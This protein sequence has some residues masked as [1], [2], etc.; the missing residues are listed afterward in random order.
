V[1]E[2]LSAFER[3]RPKLRLSIASK[4]G[5]RPKPAAPPAAAPASNG[6]TPPAESS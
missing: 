2:V 3:I 6:S 5:S 1:E 4:G